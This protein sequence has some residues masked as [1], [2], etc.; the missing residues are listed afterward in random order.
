VCVFFGYNSMEVV[1]SNFCVFNFSFWCMCYVFWCNYGSYE[2]Q[3]FFYGIC[4]SFFW[5]SFLV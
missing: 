1:N 2:L 5:V 3:L 4:T